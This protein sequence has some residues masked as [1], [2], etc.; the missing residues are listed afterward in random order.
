MVLRDAHYYAFSEVLHADRWVEAP[1]ELLVLVL[2]ILMVI[3]YQTAGGKVQP[4][5]IMHQTLKIILQE[6]LYLLQRRLQSKAY[7]KVVESRVLQA[8]V[9]YQ[10]V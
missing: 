8:T 3:W 1:I 7:L 9:A 5:L 4:W 10:V 2:W 6:W